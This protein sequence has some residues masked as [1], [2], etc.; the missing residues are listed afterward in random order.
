MK[1]RTSH[2]SIA[3]TLATFVFA[4]AAN[5]QE[6]GP[7]RPGN[8]FNFA[9]NVWKTEVSRLPSAIPAEV[10]NVRPGSVPKQ[11][12]L[13]GGPDPNFFSKPVPVARPPQVQQN[14]TPRMV[15]SPVIAKGTY[16]PAFGMPAQP[17]Q[18][19]ALQPSPA[20]MTPAV[21]Q[22]QGMQQPMG[23]ARAAAR[24]HVSTGVSGRIVSARKPRGLA[25][26]PAVA[27]YGNGFGYQP[28][29]FTPPVQSAGGRSASTTVHGVLVHKHK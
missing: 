19:I 5:A 2:L 3:L 13:L 28:G 1:L 20:P 21:V 11:N 16:S 9:P 27:S 10:H 25:A 17:P 26:G 23:Q 6:G 24:R 8:R 4:Q 12:S 15:S 22:P 29:A 14:V 18:Q 7:Q